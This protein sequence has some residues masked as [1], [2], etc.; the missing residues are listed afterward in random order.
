MDSLDGNASR[1]RRQ[2]FNL[3][4]AMRRAN[5]S[6]LGYKATLKYFSRILKTCSLHESRRPCVL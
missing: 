5:G 6:N 4:P 1:L 2:L 3:F